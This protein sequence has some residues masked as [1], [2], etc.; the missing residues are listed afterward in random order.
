M[1]QSNNLSSMISKNELKK[2]KCCKLECFRM[3]DGKKLVEDTKRVA[4]MDKLTRRSFLHSMF[5]K[6]FKAYRYSGNGVC[7]KFLRETFLFSVDM[8]WKSKQRMLDLKQM[9][10]HSI[11]ESDYETDSEHDEPAAQSDPSPPSAA[12]ADVASE[13]SM[14]NTSV[15]MKGTSCTSD[16]PFWLGK[17]KGIKRDSDGNLMKIVVHWFEKSGNA[18][19]GSYSPC[20]NKK[21]LEWVDSV[22]AQSVILEIPELLHGRL[23]AY[24]RD[25]LKRYLESS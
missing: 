23:D 10:S 13:D 24:S 11:P 5:V 20:T 15:A 16:E 6:E 8:Q 1:D 4:K 3:V 25:Y 2:T 7:Y 19:N 21:G 18:I 22:S 17:V 9:R 14:V 12:R